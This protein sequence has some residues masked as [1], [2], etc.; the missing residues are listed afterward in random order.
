MDKLL[1]W[2][3]CFVTSMLYGITYCKSLECKQKE[4]CKLPNCFCSTFNHPLLRVSEIPQIVYFGFDDALTP[5]VDPLYKKLFR[6]NRTN[7]NGCSIGM[8]L[9]V[10]NQ[11]TSY[12]EVREFYGRGME[13]ASHSV[14]HS[15]IRTEQTLFKEARLQKQNL[16]R[17][18]GIPESEIIGWRSPFLETAGDYQPDVLRKLG[19]EYDISL[20]YTRRHMKAHNPW[21]FTADYGWPYQCQMK[22]CLTKPHPGFWEFP[23]NSMMDFKDQYPCNY[24]DGCLNRPKNETEAYKYLIDNFN[25][26]YRGNRAPL[27]IHMHAAWF[28]SKYNFRA[29]DRFITE[30]LKRSDVYIVPVKHVLAWMKHPTSLSDIKKFQPWQ[31]KTGNVVP[32][33][34]QSTPKVK[35][36]TK[37]PTTR[38]TTIPS[39]AA[40]TTTTRTTSSTTTTTTHSPTTTTTTPSSTTIKSTTPSPTTTA[41]STTT[42]STSI[43]STKSPFSVPILSEQWP[44]TY[45]YIKLTHQTKFADFATHRPTEMHRQPTYQQPASSSASSNNFNWSWMWN[46]F[47]N[48]QQ[49]QAVQSK[50]GEQNSAENS[51]ETCIQGLNCKLPGCFC[52][53]GKTPGG[54]GRENT[55]QFVYISFDGDIDSRVFFRFKKIFSGDRKNPNNCPISSTFFVS[56]EG[57]RDSFVS[58]LNNKSQEIAMRGSSSSIAN[59]AEFRR[60]LAQQKGRMKRNRVQVTGWRSPELKPFGDGQYSGLVE[61]GLQYDSTLVLQENEKV[62]PF[63]LDYGWKDHCIIPECPKKKYRGLWEVPNIPVKDY[64]NRYPCNYVD[65]CMFSPKTAEETFQFL[66]NNFYNF[67]NSNKTPFGVNFRHIWFTHSAY[68]NNARGFEMFLDKL[69]QMKDVYIVSTAKLI[70]WMKNPLQLS[71]MQFRFRC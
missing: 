69:E 33:L 40:T 30:I 36:T 26:A 54:F 47:L 1:I 23:V 58:F 62:W 67:Y 10:S 2:M 35:H 24:V 71:E 57:S 16:A 11:Y 51:K 34:S 21:P 27:G 19:Y 31:C 41:T 18:G 65:G 53:G 60:Q 7:P 46:G 59:I 61:E 4:N 9:Y 15:H 44:F 6:S 56:Q 70:E 68:R 3:F 55:P 48:K 42:K 63:T 29:M 13:I 49:Q 32:I 38:A 22:P 52:Q 5:L 43:K 12:A 25:N 50:N 64:L 37:T 14:H 66:W 17:L 20:T 8:T 39:T 45:K 28:V